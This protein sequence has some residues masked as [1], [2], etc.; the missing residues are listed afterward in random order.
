MSTTSAT[1]RTADLG[2]RHALIAVGL[3]LAVLLQPLDAPT[4]HA[5]P[6]DSPSPVLDQPVMPLPD[7]RTTKD[8][9]IESAPASACNMGCIT[10]ALVMNVH[11]D[12]AEFKIETNAPVTL[13]LEV[14][15][16]TGNNG[17]HGWGPLEA[18]DATTVPTESWTPTL[19]GL[20]PDKKHGYV[21]RA[22]DSWGNEQVRF[23]VFFTPPS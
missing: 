14:R 6:D 22:R 11:A 9:H 15:P 21:L 17:W 20:K 2:A 12:S 3:A 7:T 10:T 13:T 4:A 19:T 1:S 23:G 18:S 8:P 16:E 5:A